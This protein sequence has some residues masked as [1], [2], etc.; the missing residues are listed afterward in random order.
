MVIT[1]DGPGGSGKSTVAGRLAERLGFAHLDSGAIYRALTCWVLERGRL[2]EAELLRLLED[3]S[4]TMTWGKV[5]LHDK[6]LSK[7]I[8]QPEVTSQVFRVADLPEV[9]KAVNSF[10]R[11]LA[12]RRSTVAE[13]RD[14]GTEAF[15][16]AALKV[17]LDAHPEERA[18]RRGAQGEG[19]TPEALAE[20]VHRERARPV[21]G[22]KPAPDAFHIDAT[23]IP[24]DEVV[25]RIVAEARRLGLVHAET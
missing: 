23:H 7:A 6:D 10:L 19:E 3:G 2:D 4:L 14:M 5:S 24:A 15:P 9:R 25:D 22:L 11:D 8:R 18:R 1:I 13:G 21:G 17:F 16:D 20:R 12:K